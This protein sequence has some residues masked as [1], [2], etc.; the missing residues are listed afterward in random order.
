MHFIRLSLSGITAALLLSVSGGAVQAASFKDVPSTHPAYA[1]VEYLKSAGIVSGYADGTFQPNKSVNRAEALK[2]ILTPVLPQDGLAV[3]KK[4]PFSDVP[5]GSWFLPYV[6]SARVTLGIVAG[7]PEK[8]AFNPSSNVKRA[9]FLKMFLL[10]QRI[11]VGGSY[12]ELSK[13]L[14][15]DALQSEWHFPFMRYALAS[16]MV[17]VDEQGMM[18]PGEDL[19]RGD[20]AQMIYWFTMYQQGRRTQSLLSE[21]ESEI[22]NVMSMIE[23]DDL[24]QAQFASAR[25]ILAARGALS[26]DPDKAVVKG[27]VKT[28]EGFGMIVESYRAGKEGRLDDA[29]RLAGEAWNAAKR[30]QELS[31]SLASVATQMQ[32]L[33]KQLADSAREMQ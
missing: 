3:Y 7:P 21:T 12:A 17:I 8:T 30:A 20:I 28:A 24:S 32:T 11:D 31:P 16:S 33:S 6:E 14:A 27:A 4:S 13:S 23:G 19:T 22:V 18:S 26:A 10:T 9:E 29:I 1:A 15:P 25:A 2:L 5:E